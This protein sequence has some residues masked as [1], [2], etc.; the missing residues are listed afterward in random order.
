MQLQINKKNFRD[1]RAVMPSL[2]LR[3]GQARITIDRFALTA[4]NVSYAL[5]GDYIGYWGYYPTDDQSWGN[6]CVWGIGVVAD[7]GDTQLETGERV[8]GFWPMASEVLITPGRVREASFDDVSEHRS[9]L[10]SLYN[11]YQRTAVEPKALRALEDERSIYF[12]LFMTSYLLCDFL[13]S[14]DWFQAEQIIIGSVSSKTGFGLALFLK[15]SA[16]K[17]RVVGLT[18]EA[19][20][21]FVQQLN[22]C[23]QILT[24]GSED[25]LDDLPSAYVDMSG[26]SQVRA[27]LHK[28]LNTNL[29][30]DQMVGATHWNSTG[31]V[32]ELSGAEPQFFFAPAQITR[33]D[34][35]WGR[36]KLAAL[37]VE[38]TLQ[39]ILSMQHTLAIERVAGQAQ[40]T[41][42]WHGLLDNQVSGARGIICSLSREW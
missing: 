41:S 11:R 15:Q 37:A 38:Q 25:E 34:E 12:P 2:G 27:A 24:Y 21:E 10:P 14:E 9:S 36:G 1:V 18:S 28:R 16:Y 5:S 29:V 26:D 19:N 30:S 23:D 32:Q 4:N 35:E 42:V 22:C 20:I 33:R 8:Y 40:V 6:L 7:A 13:K 17:G 39:L 3:S 31:R